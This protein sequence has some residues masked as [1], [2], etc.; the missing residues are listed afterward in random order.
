M[1]TPVI[2]WT[3]EEEATW[4]EVVL[5]T[6]VVVR[7]FRSVTERTGHKIAITEKAPQVVPGGGER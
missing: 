4:G 7:S 3:G 2:F 5:C 1:S 6:G